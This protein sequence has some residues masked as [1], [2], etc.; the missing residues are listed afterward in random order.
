MFL[1]KLFGGR[2]MTTLAAGATAP[3]FTLPGMDGKQFS[4]REALTRGPVVLAF[5]K[6]SCPVCQF[7]F[8]FIERIYNGHGSGN[9]TIVGI[10]QN[11]R[12]ETAAF[13]KE[14]GLTFPMLLDDTK[15][16]PVSNAYGLTNVPTVFWIAQDGN[17]E[18]SS[19]GWLRSDIEAINF[20]AAQ[21]D[22]AT[23]V[24]VFRS[25]E[26]IPDFRAG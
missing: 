17:I 25:N 4:L 8:P 7:A 26:D 15:S 20:R 9:V 2:K 22:E 6:V 21:A 16:Y 19:V 24:P 5:F 3:D 11:D 12:K 18:I 10:S 13:V 23:L 1:S 14:Y